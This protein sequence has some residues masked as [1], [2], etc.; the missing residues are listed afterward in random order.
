MT[1]EVYEPVLTHHRDH[2]GIAAQ[3][4]VLLT[5]RGRHRYQ[6]H[7]DW[8]DLDAEARNFVDDLAK[9]GQ[10]PDVIRMEQQAAGDTRSRPA[11]T[12]DGLDGHDVMV[13]LLT[14]CADT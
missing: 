3:E 6:G 4:P 14:T 7:G 11:K 13:T 5:D 12:G 8:Q 9:A 10:L 1:G 2:Q